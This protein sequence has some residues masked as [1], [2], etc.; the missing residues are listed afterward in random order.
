VTEMIRI[1][2]EHYPEIIQ[3]AR[4]MDEDHGTPHFEPGLGFIVDDPE[5]LEVPMRWIAHLPLIE[6]SMKALDHVHPH[7]LDV[8]V[9][10]H[11]RREGEAPELTDSEAYCFVC[12][13]HTPQVA[14]AAS[15][16]GLWMAANFLNDRFEGWEYYEPS[17]VFNPMRGWDAREIPDA[18]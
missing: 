16:E 3:A 11:L 14:I 4:W 5:G 1:T 6:Q 13:E 18:G 8:D 10:E 17:E 7:P 2:R 9:I 15:S 12:G